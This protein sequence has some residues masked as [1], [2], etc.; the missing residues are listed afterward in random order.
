ME[1]SEFIGKVRDYYYDFYLDFPTIQ[2]VQN[3]KLTN[4]ERQEDTI[5]GFAFVLVEQWQIG[6]DGDSYNGN[7]YFPVRENTYIVIPFSC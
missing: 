3:S 6:L 7:L 5:E 4:L 2:D 1:V